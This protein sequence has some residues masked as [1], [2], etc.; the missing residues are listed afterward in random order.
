MMAK[1]H[2]CSVSLAQLFFFFLVFSLLYL[3][4]T[5]YDADLFI[6]SIYICELIFF[7]HPNTHIKRE[8][9]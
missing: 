9:D 1:R 6:L 8:N 2:T 5:F 4:Y 7:F 3:N